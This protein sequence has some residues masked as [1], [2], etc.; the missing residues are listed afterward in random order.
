MGGGDRVHHGIGSYGYLNH[1]LFIDTVQDE[2][3]TYGTNVLRI[4]EFSVVSLFC[5]SMLPDQ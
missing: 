1:G 5:I 3:D 2:V 4:F